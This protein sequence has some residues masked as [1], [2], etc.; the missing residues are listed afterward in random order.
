LKLVNKASMMS[1]YKE[2]KKILRWSKKLRKISIERMGNT[3]TSKNRSMD[4]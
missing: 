2:E 3:L 1:I 4:K